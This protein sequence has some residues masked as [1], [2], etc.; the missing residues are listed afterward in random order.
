M[1]SKV[2]NILVSRLGRIASAHDLTMAIAES[3][4]GGGLCSAIVAN[5]EAS[6]TLERGF[7]VYSIDAKCELLG[8]ERQRVEECAGVS[9]DIARAMARAA[10]TK[11]QA[12]LGIAITGFAGPPEGE[13]EVGLVHI[14]AARDSRSWHRELHLGEIGREA[15]CKEAIREALELAI[16]AARDVR[17]SETTNIAFPVNDAASAPVTETASARPRYLS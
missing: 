6:G 4:T 9:E 3:C 8:L 14:A 17:S 15:V 13:E 1:N 16:L 12:G 5:T 11:S 2:H 7:V 10:L